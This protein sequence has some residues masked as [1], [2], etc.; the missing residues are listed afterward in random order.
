MLTSPLRVV[1]AVGPAGAASAA[2]PS[3]RNRLVHGEALA[4]MATLPEESF[5]AIYLDPPFFTG[6]ARHVRKGDDGPSYDDAWEGGLHGYLEWLEARLIRA[7]E[8]LR[9]EGAFFLHLD[10]H[11]VH[12][13]KVL[14][15]RLY[16]MRCF[17]NEF[18]WYYS[19]G[20]ASRRRFARKHDTVLYYTKDPVKWKFYVDRIR[21][22]HKWTEGQ[23]RADGSARDY[24]K[25]KLPDDVWEYHALLP[26]AEE[27]VG[28]PTQKPAALLER[29]L[30][31]VTDPGDLVG[32]FLCGSG[33]TA[34]AA[35]RLERNWVVADESREAVCLAAERV[36]QLLV[37]DCLP[38]T[39]PRARARAHTRH[40]RITADPTRLGLDT[41]TLTACQLTLIPQQGFNVEILENLAETPMP[42]PKVE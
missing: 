9:P 13:A 11:A 24:T 16:G 15:D 3:G 5:D 41:A 1:Q 28:Y 4:V 22:P 33:T 20:G 37:P 39:D 10:W 30:L 31:A 34:V 7:R 27:N 38:R 8:L 12:Y 17:Q 29:L 40:A 21:T 42:A 36:A 23:R 6:Q 32:D 18:V 19:G 2:L 26:W 25:G 35:Q 14:L